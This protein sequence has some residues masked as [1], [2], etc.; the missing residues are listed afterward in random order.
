LSRAKP[1]HL[2]HAWP[3]R[4]AGCPGDSVWPPA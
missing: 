1:A 4:P 2:R 3:R